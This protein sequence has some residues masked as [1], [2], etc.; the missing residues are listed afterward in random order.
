[1]ARTVRSI[2]CSRT[3]NPD[4]LSASLVDHRSKIT[5]DRKSQEEIPVKVPHGNPMETRW[6]PEEIQLGEELRASSLEQEYFDYFCL[7]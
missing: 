6:K 5:E 2:A 7:L 3:S 1:M 4:I